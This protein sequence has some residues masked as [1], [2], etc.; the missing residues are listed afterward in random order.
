[1]NTVLQ[2]RTKGDEIFNSISHGVGIALAVAATVLL[3]VRASLLGTVWHIVSFSIFGLGMI[4]L[5]T[6]S[7]QIGRAS[8]RERV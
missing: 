8:C 7:T 6:S 2:R 5:Y 4:L 3:V 1:M